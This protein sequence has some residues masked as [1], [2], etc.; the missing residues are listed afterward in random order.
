MSETTGTGLSFLANLK[1]ALGC[2]HTSQVFVS[3]RRKELNIA[4]QRSRVGCFFLPD[5]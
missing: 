3:V 1:L 5:W 4:E 2:D